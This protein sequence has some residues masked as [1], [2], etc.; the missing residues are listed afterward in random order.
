MRPFTSRSDEAHNSSVASIEVP[1]VE[2]APIMPT[3]R[4]RTSLKMQL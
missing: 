4:I 1:A 3:Q 2:D